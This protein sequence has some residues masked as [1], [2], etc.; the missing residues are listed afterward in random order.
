MMDKSKLLN[1]TPSSSGKLT[2]E[3]TKPNEP[4]SND[5]VEKS[6]TPKPA[7]VS[8]NFEISKKMTEVDEEKEEPFFFTWKDFIDRNFYI[9]GAWTLDYYFSVRGAENFHI[10]LWIAKDLAWAQDLYIPAA[11]FGSL[12]VAW[13]FVLA[14][15][16]MKYG[17]IEEVYMLIATVLWLTG[18]FVWMVGEVLYD[19]DDYVVPRTA[20]MF[21]VSA[22]FCG[23]LVH[24]YCLLNRVR[25]HG[26]YFITLFYDRSDY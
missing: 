1:G 12:A 18:N 3:D 25:L 10:Y 22:Q 23:F 13:C 26:C 14:Y 16:A 4:V 20:T 6:F 5:D 9:S 21:E 7:Y 11:L 2:H 15:Y 19:D 17:G 24:V 8:E